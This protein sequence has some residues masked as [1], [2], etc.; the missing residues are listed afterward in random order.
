VLFRS[1]EGSREFFDKDY[2]WWAFNF[3]SNWADL[4]Y[5]YMIEDIKKVQKEFED[6]FFEN[7]PAIDKTAL[8]LYNKDPELAKQFLTTYSNTMATTV[9]D[10]WWKLADELVFK[11]YDGYVDGKSVGYP[12][13]WLE[14]VGFGDTVGK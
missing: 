11:Y 5:S 9:V 4:K 2:A 12:T 7:Q 3:V 1:S 14:E 13:W 6:Q 10:R 8:E